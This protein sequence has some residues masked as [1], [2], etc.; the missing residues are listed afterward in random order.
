[1]FPML[2]RISQPTGAIAVVNQ[3]SCKRLTLAPRGMTLNPA[4]VAHRSRLYAKDSAALHLGVLLKSYLSTRT[5]VSSESAQETLLMLAAEDKELYN[6][7]ANVCPA[8]GSLAPRPV[9]IT[10]L[11]FGDDPLYCNAMR[12]YLDAL[13]HLAATSIPLDDGGSALAAM[14]IRMSVLAG[15]DA[16]WFVEQVTAQALG[17]V[18]STVRGELAA[19]VRWAP[20]GSASGIRSEFVALPSGRSLDECL[21]LLQNYFLSLK[22]AYEAPFPYSIATMH[23]NIRTDAWAAAQHNASAAF[24]ELM[25]GKACVCKSVALKESEE[26]AN[27]QPLDVFLRI[28]PRTA[29]DA[30]TG[31]WRPIDVATALTRQ[32]AFH[33]LLLGN[34]AFEHEIVNYCLTLSAGGLVADSELAHW[35]LHTCAVQ[36]NAFQLRDQVSLY[37]THPRSGGRLAGVPICSP[38]SWIWRLESAIVPVEM[39]TQNFY[40]VPCH[41]DSVPPGD[42]RLGRPFDEFFS[43]AYRLFAN[44]FGSAT[45]PPNEDFERLPLA[46]AVVDSV[47]DPAVREAEEYALA[48]FCIDASSQRISVGDAYTFCAQKRAPPSLTKF[49]LQSSLRFGIGVSLLE[50]MDRA[51]AAL[52]HGQTKDDTMACGVQRMRRLADAALRV[53]AG[54]KRHRAEVSDMNPSRVK[55]LLEA[56]GLSVDREERMPTARE[57][58]PAS[59]SEVVQVLSSQVLSGPPSSELHEH[60]CQAAFDTR[61]RGDMSSLAAAA[62]VLRSGSTAITGTLFVVSQEAKD[63]AIGFARIDYSGNLE[64][65]TPGAIVDTPIRSVLLYKFG[66]KGTRITATGKSGRSKSVV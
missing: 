61:H 44:T 1:M 24:F 30:S 19:C 8:D 49:M 9:A 55:Y 52:E 34:A 32:D 63:A 57:A 7:S 42:S 53:S 65:V 31:E 33:A 62:T 20:P 58:S 18:P 16:Q 43:R 15:V 46:P 50:A 26:S 29:L 3:A 23:S 38:G 12:D 22:V 66:T 64:N 41:R 59:Y 4:L 60:A 2:P 25:E 6:A 36:A 28:C 21:A 13:A 47:G 27:V 40:V 10:L 11:A 39:V 37:A 17:A 35:C 45:K 51:S 48:A 56:C 54:C 5:V 14:Q